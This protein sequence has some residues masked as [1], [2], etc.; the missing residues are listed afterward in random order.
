MFKSLNHFLKIQRVIV[1]IRW[2]IFTKVW[3]MKIGK[4]TVISLRTKMDMTNPKGI[5]IGEDTYIAFEVSILA[6][7]MCRAKKVD[8]FIGDRCFIGCKSIVLPGVRVG[9]ECIVAAGSVVT[10][11]VPDRCIVAGNPAAIVKRDIQ[12]GRFG[13]LKKS[14]ES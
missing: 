11:D 12:V 14:K 3:G 1:R 6:H 5:H 8:T 10:K 13:V 9:N 2:L 4:S 7:D